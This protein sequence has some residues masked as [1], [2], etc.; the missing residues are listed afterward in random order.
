MKTVGRTWMVAAALA[1]ASSCGGSA[2]GRT[3]RAGAGSATMAT[4]PPLRL[5]LNVLVARGA[6]SL[7]REGGWEAAAG[8]TL[9]GL[10]ELKVARQG[11]IVELGRGEAAGRLWLRAGARVCLGQDE[12]GVHIAVMEGQVRLRRHGAALVL[13]VED[14]KGAHAVDGDLLLAA[15]A[16]GGTDAIATGVR[17]QLADWSLLL[18]SAETGAGIG[19]MEA[20]GAEEAAHAEPLE[21]RRV[22][23][24]VHTAGD[25]AMT[26]VEHV[27]YNPAHERREGTFRFPV[28]DRAMLTGLALEIEG[29]LVEGEIV[30]RDKAREAYEKV[31]D[32]M[33]DPAL[34]EWEEGNWFKLRVFPIEPEAEKRVVIRYVS[35]LSH[36]AEGWEYDY[37]LA[38]AQAGES[39]G[40]LTV[41]VDGVVVE[42]ATKV[43]RGIDLAV[44]VAAERVPQVMREER[45]D[46]VYTA[47]RVAPAW[48]ELGGGAKAAAGP[49]RVVVLYDSSR[50]ALEAGVLARQLLHDA[51][52]ELAPGDSFVVLAADVEIAASAPALSP[53]T[54]A[55]VDAALAFVG[56]IEPDG[57]S[58]LGAGLR[59]ALALHPTD[60]IYIGDGIPTWGE[61]RATELA[62]LA[63]APGVGRIHA[64]L[65]G[66]GASSELWGELAG[67]SGGRALIVRTPLDARRFALAT[68][69]GGVARRLQAARVEAPA[70]ATLFP[71]GATT[72]FPGDEITV[73]MRTPAGTPAP[74]ALHLVGRVGDAAVSQDVAIAPAVTVAHV[75][76][77][78]GAAQ[79]GVLEASGAPREDIVKLSQDVGVLSKYTSL[80]VLENDEAYAQF[81]IERKH[82]AEQALAQAAAPQVTGGD[83]D[84]LGARRASLSPDEVQ[85]GDPEIK[86]PAPADA[87]RVVCS[88]PFG[89]T[90]VAEWDADVQAWMVRFLIDKDTP[91]GEYQVR[92][93]VTHADGHVE[94]LHLRYTVD[95]AAPAMQL[96]ATREPGG[97]GWKISARQVGTVGGVRGK[98]ADRVEVVLPDRTIL[99][100]DQV[101]PGRFEAVWQPDVA[102]VAPV[103]LRVVVRDHALNQATTELVI[104]ATGAGR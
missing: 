44:P 25:L 34:L 47:V 76:Q 7:R 19:R 73:V 29:K 96:L 59:A 99:R 80:L 103:T 2:D 79:I 104:G 91:D 53:V 75:A 77:R 89:D 45:K 57:A 65:V 24:D 10:R 11:A 72:L 21:L 95:T 6:L 42:H 33:L 97:G 39:I 8:A 5:E 31:V 69:A 62:G 102:L 9:V 61:L 3:R 60:V 16:D 90:K 30:E 71:A 12:R 94:V 18:E 86:I 26:E 38:M 88:F 101:G 32:A 20:R 84:T 27:F 41:K 74:A 63:D 23:V 51:L 87:R 1:V 28:P 49:R 66:K 36:G 92:V 48:A 100:L 58:D 14:D 52:A 13:L 82:K 64:A 85:P 56:G 93:T 83:L 81:Q 78:W 4:M 54:R 15:R 22:S 98:D 35:P 50:S 55:A 17:P 46:G 37:A 40:E 68:G 43:A 70:G 67:R